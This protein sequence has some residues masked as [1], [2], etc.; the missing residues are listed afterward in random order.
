MKKLS[1]KQV[2]DERKNAET[3]ILKVLQFFEK[4]TGRKIEGIEFEQA[5]PEGEPNE[6]KEFSAVKITVKELS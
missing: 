1:A 3:L 6:F 5:A 2:E 4:T